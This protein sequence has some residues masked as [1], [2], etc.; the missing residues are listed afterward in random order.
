MMFFA[1]LA[2]AMAIAV[3]VM[4]LFLTKYTASPSGTV[5]VDA[6]CWSR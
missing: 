1:R 6:I 5:C 3:V 4:A 2:F